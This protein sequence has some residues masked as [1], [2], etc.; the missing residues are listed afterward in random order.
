[1]N[2]KAP[3]RGKGRQRRAAALRWALAAA[4]ALLPLAAGAAAEWRLRQQGFQFEPWRYYRR[5]GANIE[6]EDIQYY[7]RDAE[8]FWRFR[9]SRT[10]RS[11]WVEKARINGHGLRGR[12]VPRRKPAGTVRILCAGDSG[13]F[14]WGVRDD[15]TYPA[16]LQKR[17]NE[18][19]AVTYETIN[20]GVPGY[21]SHQ[22]LGLLRRLLPEL[23]PDVVILSCGRNDHNPTSWLTD[24]QRKSLPRALVELQN[25]LLLSRAYQWLYM[26]TTLYMYFEHRRRFLG[27]DRETVR[28]PPEDFRRNLH[29]AADACERAGVKLA[30]VP[31]AQ[32]RA[33]IDAMK[34]VARARGLVYVD[35]EAAA[36][37]NHGIDQYLQGEHPGWPAYHDLAAVIKNALALP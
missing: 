32:E 16:Y 19:G 10:I 14:G 30:L 31:R 28:V 37:K 35:L 7:E 24:A 20:A 29:A 12:E 3:P 36:R 26:R 23:K 25:K 8:L 18:K 2:R 5:F 13:T 9:P 34:D 21:S 11:W 15:E 27:S 1:M 17:L 22:V 6:A 33:Y 4:G